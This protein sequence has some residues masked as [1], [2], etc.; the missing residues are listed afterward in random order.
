MELDRDVARAVDLED[1]RWDIPVVGELRVSV[2]VDEQDAKLPAP[3]YDPFEIRAR[4]HGRC[5]I[6]R[7]IQVQQ[8]GATEHVGRDIVQV[9]EKVCPRS[10]CVFVGCALAERGS[11]DVRRITGLGHDR[12]ISAL[13]I[14]EREMRD[15]LFGPD[16]GHHLAQRIELDAKSCAHPRGDRFPIGGQPESESIPVERGGRGTL[17]ERGDRGGRRR[18]VG[19]SGPQIDDIDAAGE[20]IALLLRDRGEHVLRQS[21]QAARHSW[22][23]QLT[24]RQRQGSRPGSGCGH[25]APGSQL[26][27]CRRVQA[28]RPRPV[29]RSLSGRLARGSLSMK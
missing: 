2:I 24:L 9:D 25:Q 29:F 11:A 18:Q 16:E 26:P 20:Q 13:D 12:Y 28:G 10:Q 1:A 15:P 6:V 14:R 21:G 5:R 22:H 23:T 17:G 7:I 8:L 4:G 3:P 19:I 27:P